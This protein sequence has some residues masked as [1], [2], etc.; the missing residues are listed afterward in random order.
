MAASASADSAQGEARKVLP[1][2]DAVADLLNDD[3]LATLSQGVL[4]KK[5]SANLPSDPAEILEFQKGSQS[6]DAH[7]GS[8]EWP[9]GRVNRE[10]PF[11][12]ERPAPGGVVRTY[13]TDMALVGAI[14]VSRKTLDEMI[15]NSE[16]HFGKWYNASS[17]MY[18]YFGGRLDEFTKEVYF[19][20]DRSK[21]CYG[22]ST[23]ASGGITSATACQVLLNKKNYGADT[24]A[25]GSV[26]DTTVPYPENT[27]KTFKAMVDGE[28][29]FTI[30]LV[31]K[32]HE[33]Q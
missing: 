33:D 20:N 26:K 12:S 7:S 27:V 13:E 15:E 28:P 1:I 4:R 6:T 22:Y 5:Y 8:D 16:V 24:E 2:F 14:K 11:V 18:A 19:P 17:E 23:S 9:L 30:K 21:P 3:D 32:P 10:T 29:M 31:S 25:D